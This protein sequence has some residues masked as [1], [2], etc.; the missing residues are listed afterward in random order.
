MFVLMTVFYLNSAKFF[1]FPI[2]F[3]EGAI[4]SLTSFGNE[5]DCAE[6]VQIATIPPGKRH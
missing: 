5:L 3:C 4:M 1:S 6:S 2:F